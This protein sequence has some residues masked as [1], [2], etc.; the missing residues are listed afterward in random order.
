[1]KQYKVWVSFSGCAAYYVEADSEEEARDI[2]I[3]EA[4]TTDCDEWDYDVDS[5]EDEEEEEEEDDN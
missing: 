5:V 1:M 3:T 4:D 2:A